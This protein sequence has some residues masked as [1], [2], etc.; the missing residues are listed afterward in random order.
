M[1]YRYAKT[2]HNEDEVTIK[3]TG[4]IRRVVE[5]QVFPDEKSVNITLDDGNEYIHTEIK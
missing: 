2:L 1:Q 5:V 3:K 4:E